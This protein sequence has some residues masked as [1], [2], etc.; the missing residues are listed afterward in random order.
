V[1]FDAAVKSAPKVPGVYLA[2]T[3]ESGPL[4]YVGMAG[5]RRGRGV[6]G[7]LEIYGRG[8]G[9]V[10]GLG[11]ACLDRA[12]ADA[13]WLVDRLAELRDGSPHRAKE[14][15]RLAVQRAN[16]H[17]R[18]AGTADGAAARALERAVLDRLD[19]AAIWNRAR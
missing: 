10:S 13:D 4:V 11:E 8:R 5:E 19:G 14:W 2:R 1:P 17:I 16:L 9:A 7:R 15:A 6:R 3:G 12:L 18:W